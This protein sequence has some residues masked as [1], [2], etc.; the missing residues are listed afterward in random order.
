MYMNVGTSTMG[1]KDESRK[2]I[3]KIRLGLGPQI[4]THC[5]EGLSFSAVIA[6]H[7]FHQRNTDE[8]YSKSMRITT[9]KTVLLVAVAIVCRWRCSWCGAHAQPSPS[10]HLATYLCLASNNK[11]EKRRQRET[12]KL[13]APSAISNILQSTYIYSFIKHQE[14]KRAYRLR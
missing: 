1:D 14:N 13:N 12:E 2:R 11:T 4:V 6:S 8:N 7:R 9:V 5:R 3:K 10:I